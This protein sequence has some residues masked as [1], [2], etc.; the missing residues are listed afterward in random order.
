MVTVLAALIEKEGKYLIARNHTD[1][2]CLYRIYN[3]VRRTEV[4]R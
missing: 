1:Q 4:I 3:S 2:Y